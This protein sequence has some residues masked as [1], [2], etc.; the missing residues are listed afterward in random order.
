VLGIWLAKTPLETAI[1]GEGAR[2]W[3]SVTADLRNRGVCDILI[4]CCDGLAG[5]EDAVY[6]AFPHT[7]MQTCVV[8]QIRNALGPVARPYPR[9]GHRRNPRLP[10]HRHRRSRRISRQTPRRIHQPRIP[11][12]LPQSPHTRFARSPGNH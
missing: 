3:A 11:R 7:V 4:A 9:Q 1:A 10:R 6:A 2:F 12:P 5:F 8:H